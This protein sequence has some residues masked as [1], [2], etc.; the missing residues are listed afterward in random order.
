MDEG[1]VLSK[2]IRAISGD[3]LTSDQSE[4]PKKERERDTKNTHSQDSIWTRSNQTFK[5]D[6]SSSRLKVTDV[7]EG[8]VSQT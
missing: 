1:S 8:N 6:K 4:L 5:T 2:R 3:R 7:K